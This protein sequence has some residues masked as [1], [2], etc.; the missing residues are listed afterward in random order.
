M[1]EVLDKDW[2][3]DEE[4]EIYKENILDHF[5]HPRNF[6]RLENCT[7]KNH[8]YNPVCGDKIEIFIVIKDNKIKEAKFFGKGC[9]I[10]MASAS[11]LTEK[12]KNMTVEELKNIKEKE[13]LDM[14]GVPLGL[15][16]VKCGLL[17]LK[18]LK[19]GLEKA[20]VIEQ[21]KLQHYRG[22]EEV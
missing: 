9:A 18:T 17:S 14:I 13:V 5:R 21:F 20:E 7:I 10:S 1:K 8:K 4:D 22:I 11:M 19:E 2:M 15:V 6:G 3:G 16:R 12:I